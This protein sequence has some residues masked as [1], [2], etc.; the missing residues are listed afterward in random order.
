[1]KNVFILFFILFFMLSCSPKVT[2]SLGNIVDTNIPVALQCPI[3]PVI[4][5][6]LYPKLTWIG[7]T[8]PQ[9]VVCL[10]D[11]GMKGLIE[12]IMMQQVYTQKLEHILEKYRIQE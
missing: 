11:N 10:D 7:P 2:T 12:L 9:S 5:P 6:P 1:M 8:N 3:P 4:D